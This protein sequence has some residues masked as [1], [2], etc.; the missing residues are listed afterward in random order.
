[1]I[2][3]RLARELRDK[4]SRGGEVEVALMDRGG[5]KHVLQA[6]FTYIPFGVLSPPATWSG[7]YDPSSIPG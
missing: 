2:A 7:P 6:G 5:F 1:M 4:I 3:N